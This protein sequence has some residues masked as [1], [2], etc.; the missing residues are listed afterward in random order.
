MRKT[1][2]KIGPGGVKCPCC[3]PYGKDIKKKL[4]RWERRKVKQE[5]KTY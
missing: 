2:K 1:H 4:N 5:L 3:N